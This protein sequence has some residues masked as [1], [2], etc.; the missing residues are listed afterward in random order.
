[1]AK[2]NFQQQIL[3]SS[4]SHNP[5]KLFSMLTTAVLL[6]IFCGNRHTF[7]SPRILW[8]IESSKEQH[9]F[10]TEIS[11]NTINGFIV[12]FDQFNASLHK[13]INLPQKKT[14]SLYSTFKLAFNIPINKTG[15]FNI[16]LY[17]M[18]SSMFP[19]KG[20]VLELMCLEKPGGTF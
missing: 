2:L 11:C 19:S 3:E 17:F 16:F 10:E 6:K 8:W 13:S 18:Y 20:C 15:T 1:M 4:V 9:L 12:T 7:F 5:I 14:F